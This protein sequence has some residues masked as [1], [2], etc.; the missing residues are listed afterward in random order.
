M[1]PSVEPNFCPE[2]EA[3]PEPVR[4]VQYLTGKPHDFM[5]SNFLVVHDHLEAEDGTV[6]VAG[7]IKAHHPHG[8]P[9]DKLTLRRISMKTGELRAIKRGHRK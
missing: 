2:A 1:N 9:S 7:Y 6:Y 4:V 3:Q 5:P 8:C